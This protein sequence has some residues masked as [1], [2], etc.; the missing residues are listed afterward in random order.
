MGKDSAISWTHSTFNPWWG[1]VEVS[2][3]CDNCYARELANRWAFPVWGKDAP[4]RFFTDKHWNEPVK[5]DAAAKKAGERHRV[6]CASMADVF[7]ERTDLD[8]WR[9]RLWEL[10][11]KT[12]NL[13][14]MLL[15]K[16]EKAIRKMLP[17]AWIAKPR[18][19][20]WMGV[21][22]ENQR[23][24]NERIPALLDIPAIVHWISA[25]PLLGPIDFSPW[26]AGYRHDVTHDG[27]DAPDGASIAGEE[28]SGGTWHRRKGID[29]VIV[30]GESGNHPRRMDPAWANDI[31]EQCKGK[32]A[33]HFKQKGRI[34]AAELGCKD[35]EGKDLSEW[36]A[37]F[38]VQE[39]PKAF[40]V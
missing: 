4:R 28:R 17:A 8:V 35:R 39:F 32:V 12:P 21:T 22:A 40:A 27:L 9:L 24:A 23:R 15:T 19:N 36:P 2:P 26:I 25:E 7:E 20:V 3:A 11:E 5:W 1:C 6:F 33:Y 31:R 34:L 14:W 30:G 29:W 13:D 16:R 37:E 38:K 10:I 18:P